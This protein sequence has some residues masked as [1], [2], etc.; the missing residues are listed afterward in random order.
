M[1]LIIALIVALVVFL[2]SATIVLFLVGPTLLLKPKR[3]TAD[4]YRALGLPVTPAE[5]GLAYEEITLPT[6]D[7]LKLS[8]WLIKASGPSRGTIVHLHGVADCKID[9]I[10]LAKLFH[11]MHYNVFLFDSR[12][13]GASEGR[14]CTFGYFEKHDVSTAIDYLETR[15]DVTV[16][17]IGLFGTSMGAAVALQSAALDARIAAVVSENSFATLRSVFDEYQRRIVKLPFHYLRNFVIKH[18]EL[19]ADFRAND[20]SPLESVGKIRIPLLFIYG[21]E[22][23]HIDHRYT[24]MLYEHAK[25]PKDLFGVRGATHNNVWKTAGDRYALKILEFF[26]R[27][28]A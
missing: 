16:G 6:R 10:S 17:K 11:G 2:L 9:G 24:I 27:Y 12:R 15:S 1:T 4:F 19:M 21:S 3:R 14:F 20:V 18:S 28:L 23:R 8:S 7:G 26:D 22:D 13:H 5:A 25:E